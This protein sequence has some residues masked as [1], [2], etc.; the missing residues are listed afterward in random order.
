MKSTSRRRS[1]DKTKL[2]LGHL[3]SST[4]PQTQVWGKKLS[5]KLSRHSSLHSSSGKSA[6]K[7]LSVPVDVD[8]DT[9]RPAPPSFN[10]IPPTPPVTDHL[11]R[12]R[13]VPNTVKLNPSTPYPATPPAAQSPTKDYWGPRIPMEE[14][15]R[16]SMITPRPLS[17]AVSSISPADGS[18]PI[19]LEATAAQRRSLVGTGTRQEDKLQ[20]L[21]SFK[22][23]RYARDY[24]DIKLT[25]FQVFIIDDSASMYG[26]YWRQVSELL[27]IITN[28]ATK[29]IDDP[30]E[31]IDVLFLNSYQFNE[32]NVRSADKI[33]SIF[34][35][36]VPHG[37]TPTANLLDHVLRG[38][39][40]EVYELQK[41]GL[42]LMEIWRQT[43][44][45][46]I[47]ILT[48][49]EPTDEPEDVIVDV[50]KKLDNLNAP[51]AQVGIQFVQIGDDPAAT[52]YLESLDDVSR[53]LEY[54]EFKT[55]KR[56][57]HSK[58]SIISATL[59]IQHPTP[60]RTLR[61]T[62]F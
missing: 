46:N 41:Q 51:L 56:N 31:G 60:A 32:S 39:L 7:N 33:I 48:D 49:G 57:R 58:M 62:R 45:V 61:R 12:R 18:P 21:K 54:H 38:Y 30:N 29:Y 27:R 42:S 15:R 35:Q 34:R 10:I 28:V 24:P 14:I 8:P 1:I 55:N 50:A 40:E 6:F 20:Q 47:V 25:N 16:D 11:T 17:P 23:V 37:V 3:P 19:E 36:V 26:I 9:F 53:C 2:H 5:S 59:S 4:A 13:T 44:P 22:T 52:E 43:K